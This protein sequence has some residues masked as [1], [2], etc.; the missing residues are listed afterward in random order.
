MKCLVTRFRDEL[1]VPPRADVQAT[2]R[3]VHGAAAGRVP[4]APR[5]ALSAPALATI[6]G[7]AHIPGA[8]LGGLRRLLRLP[9][10]ALDASAHHQPEADEVRWNLPVSPQGPKCSVRGR[11]DL[12]NAVTSR[13]YS[14]SKTYPH[15][16]R[17]LTRPLRPGASGGSAQVHQTWFLTGR[18][19]TGCTEPDQFRSSY[20]PYGTFADT[21]K[22]RNT[23]SGDSPLCTRRLASFSPLKAPVE[24][25]SAESSACGGVS[26]SRSRARNSPRYARV[27]CLRRRR[28]DQ[29]ARSLT[30][31]SRAPSARLMAISM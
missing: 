31:P 22:R 12:A 25:V 27:P 19:A 24:G 26:P 18:T 30:E 6:G 8:P 29:L 2:A 20:E 9:R 3:A 16:E 21:Y 15:T 28:S 13:V 7:C 11:S 4:A 14:R 17:R 5:C 1:R 10:G 23:G